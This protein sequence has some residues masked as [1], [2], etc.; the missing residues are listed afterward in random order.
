MGLSPYRERGR[1]DCQVRLGVKRSDFGARRPLL[2]LFL[3]AL[4]LIRGP[5]RS[6]RHKNAGPPEG[7]QLPEAPVPRG[8]WYQDPFEAADERWWDG[9][10]W[11]DQVRGP[12]EPDAEA[13]LPEPV[14]E[15]VTTKAPAVP[16]RETSRALGE[17]SRASH[18]RRPCHSCHGT[19][20]VMNPR[21]GIRVGCRT[22]RGTGM[23]K[24]RDIAAAV[25]AVMSLIT[26]SSV[27]LILFSTVGHA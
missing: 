3:L 15:D 21:L 24:R 11:T 14:G 27:V 13:S 26:V 22:C 9:G 25:L 6:T 1:F 20:R 7:A 16:V 8:A 17:A 23:S 12:A 19:G 5:A 2:G 10:K 4:F 18:G